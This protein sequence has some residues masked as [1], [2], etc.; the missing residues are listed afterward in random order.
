[1]IKYSLLA[2]SVLLVSA[3]ESSTPVANVASLAAANAVS[4]NGVVTPEVALT[5]AD[6]SQIRGQ[7]TLF[8]TADS[9]GE[10][11]ISIT[12][13]PLTFRTSPSVNRGWDISL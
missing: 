7:I 1:M 11:N 3:C 5:A 9:T 2:I 10:I 4:G 6:I 12:T 8:N 13:V